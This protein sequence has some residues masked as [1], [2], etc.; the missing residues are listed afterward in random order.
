MSER[1]QY[2]RKPERTCVKCRFF[3]ESLPQLGRGH[4]RRFPPI[5]DA[6]FPMVKADYW[7]GE[8]DCFST[9]GINWMREPHKA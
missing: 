8:F 1:G 6:E 2:A 3:V 9:D 7:C 5:K 4:C